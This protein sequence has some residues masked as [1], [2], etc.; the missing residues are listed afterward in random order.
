VDTCSGQIAADTLYSCQS[1]S[2]TGTDTYTLTLPAG[3]NV[4]VFQ[5]TDANAFALPI[6]VTAPGGGT[7]TCQQSPLDEC[8]TS[9]GGT[10]TVAVQSDDTTYTL[11]F[12][13]L[14]T[15]ASCPS[16]SLSFT[17]APA[18]GSLTAGEPG[19]CYSFTASDGDSLYV[20]GGINATQQAD[21][22]IF[23]AAGDLVCGQV[24][25]TCPLTG[26][27]PYRV[28]TSD[29]GQA[30]NYEFQIAD[31]TNPSGCAAVP[32]QAYGQLPALT[33]DL[34]G[35]LTVATA[36]SYQI[37]S[38]DKQFETQAA[39]L[40]T[41]DGTVACPGTGPFCELSPGNYNFV[42]DG[43]LEGDEVST[44]FIAATESHGCVAV[45]DTSLP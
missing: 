7:L 40:Y 29:S 36:G 21:V 13:A 18:T 43:L 27:G 44:V 1:P 34:C 38:V 5:T 24:Q 20:Y 45:K 11:E 42:Q 15:E 6:T 9:L 26:A 28:L 31:L 3:P 2:S 8:A 4:L 39:T 37:Y 17:G 10:Y 25:G 19:T 16:L 32:E 14:L 23:D 22:T 30:A 12:T 41:P 35:S 33:A